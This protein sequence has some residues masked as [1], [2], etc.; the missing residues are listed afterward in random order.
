MVK[1]KLVGQELV[2]L[3]QYLERLLN[4]KSW[5]DKAEEL[6]AGAKALEPLVRSLWGTIE[7]DF[8]EGRYSEGGEAPHQPPQ[9]LQGV[10]FMLVAYALENLFKALIIREH[11]DDIQ[12]QVLRTGG[13][14]PGIAKDHDLI[15]LA[16]AAHL[17]IDVGDEDV[18]TRLHWNSV[19]AGR[20]PLPVDC[21]GLR[22][23]KVYSDGKGYLVAC[24]YPND[25]DRLNALVQRVKTHVTNALNSPDLPMS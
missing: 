24:F 11:R 20:Y 6:L 7:A 5:I 19:W 14:L 18:L 9:N 4:C 25:I 15:R 13:K 8:K 3:V 22:N 23:V 1:K 2:F 21:G 12:D 10:Y 17:I 16:K